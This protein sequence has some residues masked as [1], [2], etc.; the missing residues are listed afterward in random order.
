LRPDTPGSVAALRRGAGV[1]R[2]GVIQRTWAL[3]IAAAICYV[4]ANLLR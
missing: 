3:L 4:S 2:H 1:Q